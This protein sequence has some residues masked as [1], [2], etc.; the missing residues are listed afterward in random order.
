MRTLSGL[1]APWNTP[2]THSK[3]R[4]KLDRDGT[5]AVASDPALVLEHKTTTHEVGRA[6]VDLADPDGIRVAA[7]LDDDDLDLTG[8]A[9]SIEVAPWEMRQAPDGVHVL[10]AGTILQV[11]LTKRPAF[12]GTQIEVD[13]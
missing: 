2:S 6:V 9:F 5:F 10:H 13:Q 11:A 8:Y 4:F 3:R 7:E 1:A 12:P